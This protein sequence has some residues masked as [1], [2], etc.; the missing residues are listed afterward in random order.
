LTS[1]QRTVSRD[2]ATDRSHT[3]LFPQV[4]RLEFREPFSDRSLVA[5]LR[6]FSQVGGGPAG[7]GL[8]CAGACRASSCARAAFRRSSVCRARFGIFLV[9]PPVRSVPAGAGAGASGP[10]SRI[11]AIHAS[12]PAPMKAS[13]SAIC[14]WSCPAVTLE[15]IEAFAF[16]FVPSP[17]VTSRLTRPSLAQA[18]TDSGSSPATAAA[19]RRT[20]AA[21]VEWSGYRFPQ[22]TGTKFRPTTTLPRTKHH[23]TG[24]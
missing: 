20:N 17:A 9:V 1:P 2:T 5:P 12:T 21:H 22:I 13:G 11:W 6:Q 8:S 23:K 7:F 18:R 15:A 24:E 3:D 16:S 14:A 19:C 10:A 4:K